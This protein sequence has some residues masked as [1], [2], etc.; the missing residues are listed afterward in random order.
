MNNKYTT[1]N[2]V[3]EDNIKAIKGGSTFEQLSEITGISVSTLFRR[4]RDPMSFTL[5][6]TY[7][8]CKYG[9]ISVQDFVS[10]R[11]KLM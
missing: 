8:L 3:I 2:K 5:G 6:E 10:H 11:L 1:Y 9:G 4:Y 7:Q